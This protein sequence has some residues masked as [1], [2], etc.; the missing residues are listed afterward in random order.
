MVFSF[1]FLVKWV[2]ELQARMKPCQSSIGYIYCW[3]VKPTERTT[4]SYLFIFVVFFFFLPCLPPPVLGVLC[5]YRSLSRPFPDCSGTAAVSG[6]QDRIGGGPGLLQGGLPRQK[7]GTSMYHATCTEGVARPLRLACALDPP[8][9]STH[10][11]HCWLM[12]LSCFSGRRFDS[13]CIYNTCIFQKAS[14]PFWRTTLPAHN[15]PWGSPNLLA[16][17]L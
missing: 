4:L 2:A 1:Q 14:A 17:W 6:H 13:I 16:C 11:P 12:V 8:P 9:T 3:I 5:S 10:H 15:T 7:V